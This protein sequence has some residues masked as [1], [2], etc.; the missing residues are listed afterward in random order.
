MVHLLPAV[1]KRAFRQIL[2]GVQLLHSCGFALMDCKPDN[3]LVSMGPWGEDVHCTVVDLGSCKK[4][5][6]G[7]PCLAIQ[8]IISLVISQGM[9]SLVNCRRT[10]IE[11]CRSVAQVASHKAR[12]RSCHPG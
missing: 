2:Q 5:T 3:I 10:V 12:G 6:A 4:F 9:S 1:T 11:Y 8:F 7:R